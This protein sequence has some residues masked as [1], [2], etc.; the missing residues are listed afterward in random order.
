MKTNML[1]LEA[2][3]RAL[4]GMLLLASPILDLPTY[5]YNLFGIVLGATGMASFCPL[6][7]I[8]KKLVASPPSAPSRTARS[9]A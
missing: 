3:I 2:G 7:T 1:P 9:H 6:K 8:V 4:T 5:P